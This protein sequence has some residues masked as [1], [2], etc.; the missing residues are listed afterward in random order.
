ME[1]KTPPELAA[2]DAALRGV[3]IEPRASLGP[4]IT[5]RAARGE[6]SYRPPRRFAGP[7]AAVWFGAV[8]AGVIGAIVAIAR[9][10]YIP[11]LDRFASTQRIE[12]CCGD[13]DGVGGQDDG[14]IIE[15]V[16][17]RRVRRMMVYEE[18]DS[19]RT[20]SDG[21]LVRFQ[22]DGKPALSEPHSYQTPLVTREICCRDF[23]N[24]GAADDGLLIVSSPAG[25]V[26]LA[27]LYDEPTTTEN[28]PIR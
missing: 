28:H 25:E 10:G 6:S 17:H 22:R 4:E 16:G 12:V 23:D 8:A 27:A 19:D 20:W 7:R 9:S 1:H 5:G 11:M 15:T 2:L 18:R 3:R 14:I 26:L 13:L 21:E 24:G